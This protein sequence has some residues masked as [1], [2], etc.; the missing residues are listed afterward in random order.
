MGESAIKTVMA[1]IQFET[2][3]AAMAAMQLWLQLWQQAEEL[4][5]I[6]L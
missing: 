3:M 2:V 5:K 4:P 6:K 1:V